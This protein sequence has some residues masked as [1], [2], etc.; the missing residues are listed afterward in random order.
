M[1]RSPDPGDRRKSVVR[2]A[3][4]TVRAVEEI[5]GPLAREG[6]RHVARYTT[7]QLELLLDFLRSSR[8]LQERHLD[9]IRS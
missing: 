6:F 2:P 9:R 5:F 3:P 1:T 7:E 4:R 8:E